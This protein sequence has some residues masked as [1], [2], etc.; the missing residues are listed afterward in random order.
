M[1]GAGK[2]GGQ[3]RKHW[4]KQE[5]QAGQM[6]QAGE[7]EAAGVLLL[8]QDQETEMERTEVPR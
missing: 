5:G 4:V 2:E 7:M 1:I 8:G 6:A 3:A